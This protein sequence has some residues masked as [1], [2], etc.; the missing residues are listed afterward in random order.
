M[1][2]TN[3]D[4]KINPAKGGF[5]FYKQIISQRDTEGITIEKAIKFVNNQ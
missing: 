1:V 5:S 3:P 2:G 4:F